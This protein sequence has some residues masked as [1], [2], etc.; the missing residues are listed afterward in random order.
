MISCQWVESENRLRLF[1]SMLLRRRKPIA[2]I[3]LCVKI[4]P[5]TALHR[6]F[7]P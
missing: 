3:G 2:P 5:R 7:H 1:D 6:A 4:G